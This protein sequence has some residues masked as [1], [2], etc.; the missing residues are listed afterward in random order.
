MKFDDMLFAMLTSK[1]D[2]CLAHLTTVVGRSGVDEIFGFLNEHVFPD[3]ADPDPGTEG[4][5]VQRLIAHM[6]FVGA[7]D[8]MLAW[9]ES[10]ND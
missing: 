2:E 4:R 3:L 8:A 10:E 1:R 9:K 5:M 7:V 6:A